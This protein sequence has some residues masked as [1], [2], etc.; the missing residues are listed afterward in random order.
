MIRRWLALLAAILLLHSLLPAAPAPDKP[1]TSD[2][3][4]FR[5][6]TG[7]GLVDQGPLPTE[8]SPTKNVVWKQKVPGAGWS[9][10]VVVGGKVFLTSAVPDGK[11]Q[12]SL[13]ALCLDAKDG[14]EVWRQELFREDTTSS[15]RPHQKNSHASPTPLVSGSRLFVHFGHMGTACLDLDGKVQWRNDKVKYSPVHGNGG[16]PI[17]AE[18]KLIFSCDGGDK[19]FVVALDAATGQ[20]AWRTD[21]KADKSPKK[22]SFS[23][24]LLID[25]KGQKQVVSPGPDAVVAYEPATGKEIWRVRYNGYSVIPRPVYGHGLVFVSTSFDSPTFLAIKPDGKG[26][27][28]GTHVAWQTNKNAPHTP[29]PLLVGDEVY[30]VSDRGIATC[31]DARTGE[32]HWSERLNATFSASPVCADGKVYVQ[33]EDGEGIVLKAGKKFEE[34]ARTKMGERT[35]ASYA[36]ADGALFLRTAEHLYRIEGK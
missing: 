22:F 24:P 2:W 34:L 19:P 6:P 25:V 33:G 17:L 28:T 35:L 13:V 32:V 3:P 18:D 12:L 21:R 7:Q 14:K 10:P 5:G 29:S 8:W 11:N 23:T 15:P 20:E 30:T 1:Q 4:E 27:V 36:V 9:S 31:Y 16:S 26:D